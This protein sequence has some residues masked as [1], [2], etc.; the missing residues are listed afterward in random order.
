MDAEVETVRKEIVGCLTGRGYD[1]FT[2]VDELRVGDEWSP[3]LF[4]EMYLCDVAIVLLGPNSIT[5]SDW[6][7]REAEVLMGR[8]AVR[9]LATVLP[10][11]V[12]TCDTKEAR[13]RG[14]GA[15]LKLQAELGVRPRN[16]LPDDPGPGGYATW[17]A[18]EFA[19]VTPPVGVARDFHRWS[20]RI[21][22][23]LKSARLHNADT[24]VDAAKALC[25]SDDEVT[26]VRAKVG[27]ELFLAHILLREG[28]KVRSEEEASALPEA[29]AALRP[30]L[31]SSQLHQL[32]HEVL[33]GWVAP[34]DA[35]P[36]TPPPPGAGERHRRLVLL[37]AYAS[38]T[39][40]Q[41]VRRTV[42][43]APARYRLFALPADE[44]VVADETSGEEALMAL[45]QATLPS[46]FALPPNAPLKPGRV[47]QDGHAGEYL[48]VDA[49]GREF[50]D[51]AAV[52]NRVHE[53]YPW[54]TVVVLVPD[55]VPP[56]DVLADLDLAR[57]VTVRPGP[58]VEH[59][60]YRLDMALADIAGGA[61]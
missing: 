54:L 27:A 45:C 36:F 56:P 57:A 59:R 15:L 35:E 8:Y 12:G 21:A 39:A 34:A 60:A 13:R 20:S 40:E 25:G 33:P 41:H 30:G 5:S 2:D 9:G 18:A 26:H 58:G 17:L 55:G 16:P 46:V 4:E 51:V 29:L 10:V 1:V 3:V 44:D 49:T 48:V 31:A 32:R 37:D 53:D 11:F 19:P 43:N 47:R 23:F 42:F 38:W 52:V 28:E 6:V 7:R 14:F 61:R 50:A 24:L 22:A